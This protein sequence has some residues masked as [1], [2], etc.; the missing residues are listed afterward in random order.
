[1]RSPDQPVRA[2]VDVPLRRHRPDGVLRRRRC[3]SRRCA[4]TGSGNLI[5]VIDVDGSAMRLGLRR[6]PPGR[7][8]RRA[9]RRRRGA[10]ATRA[11]TSSSA[12]TPTACRSAGRGTSATA[13]SSPS[14]APAPVDP[15][16]S[17]TP[18]HRAPSPGDRP[19]R[20]GRDPDPR[21]PRP[22]A[23]DHRRR[24]RRHHACAGTRDGQLR[25][26]STPS[27]RRRRSTT[28]PAASCAGSTPP[29]GCADGPDARRRRSRRA[30]RARRRGL[31]VPAT[32]P[33]GGCAGGVE[34]GDIAWSA[35]FGD[36]RR[37][38]RRSTDAVGSTVGFAY[39]A[40]GNVTQVTAPDGAS[41][42]Q[43]L[44]RG[45]PARRR[46]RAHGRDDGQGLRP[47]G[48]AGRGHR[49]QRQ[50]V[51]APRRRARP[52]R[53]VDG[54]RRRR[55]GLHV[56][57]RRRA[58]HPSPARTDGR[59]AREIDTAG[60]P[61][62]LHRSRRRTVADRVHAGRPGAPAHQPGG[63]HGEIRVR[64]R[65]PSG[66]RPRRRRRTPRSVGR[67]PRAG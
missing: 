11:T 53:R 47:P 14:T 55:D 12:S 39:D 19:R 33:Q 58:R 62:A 13:W 1:M 65:R 44:R 23:R 38:R 9:R 22:A 30:H 51:A 5:A 25:R 61:V 26:P 10:T 41:Y 66:R 54:A 16:P 18:T 52:H 43:R 7:Q 46:R 37:A 40:I 36:Q 27:A 42:R 21:R 24:R 6:G 17:T 31:G 15:V 32:R 64:R 48:P 57:P 20:R 3:A 4:T 49:R 50:R 45:R 56:P 29:S 2:C 60:R 35:T 28:T 8:G 59:G 34:P 63:A 67:D